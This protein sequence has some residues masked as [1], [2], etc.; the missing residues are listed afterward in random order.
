MDRVWKATAINRKDE[1]RLDIIIP[2]FGEHGEIKDYDKVKNLFYD[3][4]NQ[5]IPKDK[6]KTDEPYMIFHYCEN[7]AKHWFH[8]DDDRADIFFHYHWENVTHNTYYQTEGYICITNEYIFYFLPYENE[9][10]QFINKFIDEFNSAHRDN[11]Y[12]IP[13]IEDL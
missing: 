6:E 12:I 2:M 11:N 13:H 7:I 4:Q 10:I 8:L 5:Y 3:I 9:E 1:S